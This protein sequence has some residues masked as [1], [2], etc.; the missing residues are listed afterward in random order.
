MM[1]ALRA[2]QIT[3]ARVPTAAADHP[4]L[5]GRRTR[6]ILARAG[7]V[8]VLAVPVLHPLGYV[9]AHIEQPEAVR[10][11][12]LFGHRAHGRRM[13]VLVPRIRLGAACAPG[14]LVTV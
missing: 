14:E 8:I 2:P 9:A 4:V 11:E 13:I 1:A 6:G 5:A 3:F 7:L 12:T 10:R